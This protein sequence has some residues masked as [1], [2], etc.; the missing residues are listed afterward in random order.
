MQQRESGYAAQSL[1][2][3]G[4]LQWTLV[5]L[6][7]IL[8]IPFGSG[9]Q[10][11]VA[12]EE[13]KPSTKQIATINVT[14]EEVSDALAMAGKNRAEL[15][16]A[17]SDSPAQERFGMRFLIANMPDSDLT[18]LS[19]EFLLE[20]SALAWKARAE[21]PWGRDIP[22]EIFLNDVLPYANV[23][24][25]RD[26][27]RKEMLEL[28][29]PIAKKCQTPSE[30]AHQLNVEVF[31]RLNLKYSTA[32]RAPNQGPK[33][34]IATGKASCTG[35]SIV[36]ADACRAVAIPA[37]IVG[38]PL[39]AN[40]RGNHT[41]VEIWDKDWHF[42]GACEPDK[43]GLDRGW[44]VGDAAQAQKDSFEHAIYAASFA[45]SKQHFP[46]VWSMRNKTVPGVNVTERYARTT[47]P[48]GPKLLVRVLDS[49]KRR[50]VKEVVVADGETEQKGNSRGETADQNDIVSF[51]VKSG[52]T[53]T[54][55]VGTQE[56][57]VKI[58]DNAK[59]DVI[60][61]VVP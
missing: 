60:E 48:N 8:A 38:T 51:T 42:T 45:K 56:V 12:S 29:L 2:L 11:V 25:Q 37:R 13:T 32:R 17:L 15:E 47:A 44:F 39:W 4:R 16:R 40:K 46:M 6:L 9:V 41:W 53:Y 50:V 19:A 26:A 21:L 23:D 24:E 22:D 57:K 55:R 10:Q 52:A 34:S 43:E 36:L 33:E 58:S 59:E 7:A 1:G 35:L 3:R 14:D 5:I 54:V 61:V 20:N 28:C 27:W 18:S 30:A 49:E 31:P